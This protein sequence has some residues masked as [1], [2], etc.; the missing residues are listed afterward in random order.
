MVG[1]AATIGLLGLLLNQAALR[2]SL[3]RCAPGVPLP[4]S[5]LETVLVGLTV[6]L[7]AYAVLGLHPEVHSDA[8]RQ[9]LPLAREI[10]Q[11]GAA[12]RFQFLVVSDLPVA[13]HVLYA[14][15]MAWGT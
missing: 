10:W 14:V 5:W 11:T 2:Q 7:V 6:G 8:V 15:A 13:V 12:P 4:L 9:H 1:R 3:H